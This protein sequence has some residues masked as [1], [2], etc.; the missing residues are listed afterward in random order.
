[1]VLSHLHVYS[2]AALISATRN[3]RI[4]ARLTKAH[5]ATSRA[6]TCNK[7][8]SSSSGGSFW[9]GAVR[10][11]SEELSEPWQ[12]WSSESF[13]LKRV[14]LPRFINCFQDSRCPPVRRFPDVGGALHKLHK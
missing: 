6:L 9:I 8:F 4:T 10:L 13:E 1:M 3:C 5:A 12:V 2:N 11:H 14:W 7:I